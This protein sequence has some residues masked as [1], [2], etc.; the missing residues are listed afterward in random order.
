MWPWES[1][2]SSKRCGIPWN[3]KYAEHLEQWLVYR[4]NQEVLAINTYYEQLWQ[5]QKPREGN[6]FSP[7]F[8]VLK[9][10]LPSPL[11]GDFLGS[12]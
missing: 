3:T 2:C 6:G 10:P 12:G 5:F 1:D 8:L 7:M 11:T 9:W 4:K